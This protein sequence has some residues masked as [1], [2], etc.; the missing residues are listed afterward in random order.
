MKRLITI[1]IYK[2]KIYTVLM[3][4]NDNKLMI[5]IGMQ[6]TSRIKLST[7]LTPISSITA[8]GFTMI[9]G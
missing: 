1:T 4:E 2:L 7:Q 9:Y 6:G 8:D 5:N 3:C